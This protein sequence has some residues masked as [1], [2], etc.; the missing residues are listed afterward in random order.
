MD[1]HKIALVQKSFEKVAALGMK[2]AE[3]F[4]AELFSID[5]SLREMFPADL[6]EQQKKLL[7]TLA[8]A[9]RSL[10]APEKIAAPIERLAV[11]HLDYGVQP[12]HYTYVGNALM[13]TLKKGLGADFTPELFDAWVDTF[14]MLAQIMKKA[15]YGSGARVSVQGAA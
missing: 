3:I 1:A 6:K 12:E 4:Y 8:F 10:N 15:A 11:K 5:P 9:V 2:A 13:R 7:M 14:R